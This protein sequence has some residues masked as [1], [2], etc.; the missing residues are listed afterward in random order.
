ME[1]QSLRRQPLVMM[2]EAQNVQVRLSEGW[3]QVEVYRALSI[4]GLINIS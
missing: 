1:P 3:E 2:T 4:R